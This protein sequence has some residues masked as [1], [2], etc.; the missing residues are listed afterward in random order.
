MSRPL[1]GHATRYQVDGITGI[2]EVRSGDDLA[3]VVADALAATGYD[4]ADGDIVVVTSKIVSKAEGR[5]IPGADREAAIDAE[6]V[7]TVAEWTTP[8]GRTR[9]VETRHG[10]VMAAAGVDASNVEPG[11]VVLLPVDPDAS[12][13]RLRDGV[14]SR[15]GVRVGVVVT[16]TA[17]RP[18]REGVVDLAVGAAGILALDDLRGRTDAYGNDLG[19]TMV[20]VADELAAA[21]ELVRTKLSGVPVAVVRGLGHLL[22]AADAG[23][24]GAHADV[25]AA[26]PGAADPG[27]AVLVRRAADDRFRLGTPEAMRAAVTTRRT[28]REFTDGPVDPAAVRRAV[29]AALSAPAPGGARPGGFVLASSAEARRAVA[30][31]LPGAASAV[32]A[33]APVVVVPCRPPGGS[34]LA[35]GAAVENLLIALAADGLGAAWV[36]PPEA[37]ATGSPAGHATNSLAEALRLPDGWMPRGAVAI[38]RPAGEGD[39]H[40]PVE[41]DAPLV[42]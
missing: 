15:L 33:A 28:V 37:V 17:G 27:A 40:P 25:G 32:L 41:P 34:D 19:V 7:R 38:G 35:V 12:A 24:S 18:W 2:P 11:L 9:I 1:A 4:L 42:R 16:D 29:A 39:P 31:A 23:D 20:A 36:F 26:D 5:V 8:N 14:R 3:E 6:A 30:E 13:R 10:F 21:T 22:L